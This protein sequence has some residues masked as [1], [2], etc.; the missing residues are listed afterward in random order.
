[1]IGGRR[2]PESR[3]SRR[4]WRLASSRVDPRTGWT[5]AER[6]RRRSGRGPHMHDGVRR[7]VRPGLVGVLGA[8]APAAPAAAAALRVLVVVLGAVVFRAALAVRGGRCPPAAVAGRAL[9]VGLPA[10]LPGVGAWPRRRHPGRASGHPGAGAGG[11]GRPAHR[12][13]AR[14]SPARPRRPRRR[15]LP[16]P[17]RPRPPACRRAPSPD[18]SSDRSPAGWLVPARPRSRPPT[19]PAPAAGR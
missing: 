1:M 5:S 14:R 3:P 8:A 7:I 10:C 15:R 9:P 17:L 4:R 12:R 18:G 2:R 19:P 11:P 16:P 6:A 13:R